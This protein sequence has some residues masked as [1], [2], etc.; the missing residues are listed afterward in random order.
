MQA[1][2]TRGSGGECQTI[3][4]RIFHFKA[5][6]NDGSCSLGAA[7]F[8][9]RGD[10]N[11]LKVGF[12]HGFAIAIAD[13]TNLEYFGQLNFNHKCLAYCGDARS[14]DDFIGD[15]VFCMANA[16]EGRLGFGF[17][18]GCFCRSFGCF[19]SLFVSSRGFWGSYS[20]AK[21]SQCQ[22]KRCRENESQF[23][24]HANTPYLSS[25]CCLYYA[26]FRTQLSG[27]L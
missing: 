17:G 11:G 19:G 13:M 26:L 8:G 27:T 25:V 12:V 10:Q 16:L 14:D 5:S 23:L 7:F 1:I 15:A 2:E 20:G 4:A 3:G 22:K 18:F 6:A 9:L 24:Q 21:A